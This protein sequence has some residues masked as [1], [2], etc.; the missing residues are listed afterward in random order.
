MVFNYSST[1]I[2][3]D[4]KKTRLN[5]KHALARSWPTNASCRTRLGKGA[6]YNL[7]FAGVS[8]VQDGAPSFVFVCTLWGGRGVSKEK[9]T[10]YKQNAG[11]SLHFGGQFGETCVYFGGRPTKNN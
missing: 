5:M 1:G 11:D 7:K 3:G 10:K 9:K 6:G 4:S 8:K 2:E